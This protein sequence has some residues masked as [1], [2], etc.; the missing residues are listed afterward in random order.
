MSI[1]KLTPKQEVFVREYLVDLNAT[2]AAKAAGSSEKPTATAPHE[3]RSRNKRRPCHA[4]S[5]V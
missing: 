2:R 4:K 3:E 5:T 1:K